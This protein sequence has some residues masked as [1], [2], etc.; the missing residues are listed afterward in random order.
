[1]L[2]SH[3]GPRSEKGGRLSH[4]VADVNVHHRKIEQY[5]PGEEYFM[6]A[7]EYHHTP[8]DGVVITVMQKQ[9][10][11]EIHANSVCRQGIDFHY[12]FD[13]FQL[14]PDQLFAYVT[15]AFNV[16]N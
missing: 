10:E 16:S 13:R 3:N 14:S 5:G 12:D 2:I 4:P 7:Y 11:G 15:D 1:M 6:P 9:D 8:C